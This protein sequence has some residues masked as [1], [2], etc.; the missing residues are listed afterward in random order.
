MMLFWRFVLVVMDVVDVLFVGLMLLEL[1]VVVRCCG[2]IVVL[3][4]V[5]C[6]IVDVALSC[7]D[8][9]HSSLQLSLIHI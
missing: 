3:G 1:F 8:V 9:T 5:L 2:L 4:A 7:C 6:C